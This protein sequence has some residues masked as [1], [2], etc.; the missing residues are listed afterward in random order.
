MIELLFALGA[1]KVIGLSRMLGVSSGGSCFCIHAANGIFHSSDAAHIWFSLVFEFALLES[2]S[3]WDRLFL[4]AHHPFFLLHLLPGFLMYAH[5]TGHHGH[6]VGHGL[7]M[8]GH[9]L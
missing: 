7:H 9:R 3:R 5:R 2:Q 4:V 6:A 1:A 8:V